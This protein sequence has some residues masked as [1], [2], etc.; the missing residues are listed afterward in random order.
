MLLAVLICPPTTS[1]SITKTRIESFCKI[2]N[3]HNYRIANLLNVPGYRSSSIS[4]NGTKLQDWLSAREQII[5]SLS[6]VTHVL[7]GYGVSPPSGIA[8]HYF[9]MQT[10]W[11]S[12]LLAELPVQVYF[13][14]DGPRHPSRWQRYTAKNFPQMSF[15]EALEASIHCVD[16]GSLIKQAGDIVHISQVS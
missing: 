16:K 13:V 10:E 6:G 11:L 8:K 15:V 2:L 7:L 14:G 5:D 3:I 1:G 9:R 12:N 4:V